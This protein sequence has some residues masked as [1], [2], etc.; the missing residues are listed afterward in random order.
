MR[1]RSVVVSLF[2]ILVS[3][4]C[5]AAITGTVITTDGLAVSGAKVAIFVP[6]SSDARRVRLLSKTPTR[7]PL[8]TAQSDSKGNF[9]IEAPKEP[10]LDVRIEANGYAP[11]ATRTIGDE[12]LGAI[13]LIAAPMLKGTIT[14][15]GKAVSGAVIVA[16]GGAEYTTTT[17]ADG[18]YTL[19]DPTK[20]ANRLVILHPDHAV[21]EE[22]FGPFGNAKKGLDRSLEAGVS[23]AGKVVSQ[24]GTTGVAN[25]PIFVDGWPV[26][27]TGE[28][29]TFKVAHAAKDWALV[30][31]RVDNR[32]G[33]RAHAAGN[34]AIKLAKAAAIAGLVLDSKTQT[35]LAGVEVRLMPAGMG[36]GGGGNA[37]MGRSSF[38]NAKGG[39][40][41]SSVLPGAYQLNPTR[42]GF[43]IP[44]VSVSVIAGQSAQKS[45]YANARAR[46]LGSVT[47]EDKRPV[48]GARVASRAAARDQMTMMMGGRNFG[49]DAGTYSAPDGRFVLRSVATDSDIQIDAQKKGYPS[50]RSATLKLAPAERKSGVNITVPRG[51]A[52]TGKVMDRDGRG[53]SGVGV[54]AVEST[55]DGGFG[56]GARRMILA[57][58]NARA[59][60]LVRTTSDG[61]FTIRV[62]EGT[63]DVVFKREGFA[64]KTVRGQAVSATT[65]PLEVT[66]DPGVEITGRVTRNG[67]GVEGV[68]VAAMSQDG[69]ASAISGPDG[70]FRLEDL[71]PGQMMLT[72]GKREEFIQQ[73]RPI[74]APARDVVIEVPAGGRISGRVVDKNT[75]APVTAFQAGISTSRGGGGMM[76]MTPPMLKAFTTDDGT[77]TLENVP[78]GPTQ[79]VVSA[80]GYTTTRLPSITV[81]EGKPV[82]DL[83]VALDTG[84]KLTGRVTGPD[85]GPLGGVTVRQD[86]MQSSGRMIARFD[87]MESSTV[88]DPSGEYTIEAIE[89]GEKSFSFTRQGYLAETKTAT[90]SGSSGRLDAQL[91]TGVRL[92]GSVVSEGGGPV[93]E[94]LV[95]ASSASNSG[96]GGGNQARTDAS[97]NFQIEGLAPGHY[98]LSATKT[99]YTNGV[100]RDF[101][102]AAGAPARIIMK[103]GGTIMG[104]VT[105]LT[106]QELRSATVSANSANGNASAPVDAS[107]NFK[108][109][110]APVGTVRVSARTG[111]MFAASGKSS[112]MKS[113]QVEPGA[114]VQVDLEFKSGTVVRG[115]VTRDNRVLANAGVVFMP[116]G[117][118]SQ[119]VASATTDANG[120][121]EISGLDDATY[122]V[123][124]MDFA[125]TM[126]FTTTYEVK[127]S[128]TF[129]IDIKASS[130]RGRVTDATTGA[131]LADAR[132]EIHA[133]GSD[134]MMSSRVVTTDSNGA[135]VFDSVARGNY[136]ARADKEGYGHDLRTVVVGDSPEDLEFKLSPSG[137]V[138]LTVVDARDNRQISA[139]VGRIVDAQG[140]DVDSIPNFRFGGA[141]EPMKLTLSSGTYRITL[142]AMGYA[143]QTVTV[144]S[145]SN[146]TV[147][148]TPGGSV[149][150]RSKSTTTTRARLVDSNGLAYM[151]SAFGGTG[152]V[153]TVDANPGVTT[154]QNIAPGT[155]RLEVLG[156]GD[157][158]IKTVP[159][160]VVDGQPTQVE[161]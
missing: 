40:T 86:Q 69:N 38:T 137:G 139:N 67:T 24:D 128:G 133:P 19:P 114:S 35:P 148:M 59:E 1:M 89:P 47:D 135:F 6:E 160:T 134:T 64:A 80:A 34:L 108:L 73:F 33:S 51:I 28:D 127:G 117:A 78:P 84:V 72:A 30:E 37:G 4:P 16:G 159:L 118:Q 112:P 154:L 104:H 56:G 55:S 98:M 110:G 149:V 113:V 85:G 65:K 41:L 141:L 79:I 22:N 101:D 153:F 96:F 126:P 119:T 122:N 143:T 125:R 93:G 2:G 11:D 92:T 71:T 31:A 124:V 157:Q 131:P 25:A 144:V 107:G 14:A 116:K 83:E 13:A 18:R 68:N 91:T 106:D 90:L 76:I 42:P 44:N 74:T 17:D 39:Y 102:V 61:T 155:F 20:W 60:N 111:G 62:K 43:V 66:L 52:L 54:E 49:Q 152:G 12:D 9:S 140:R 26:A 36:M 5:F 123:Q 115:R 29:G 7:T 142:S 75:H 120:H 97:G 50:G 138:T 57:M 109:E 146:P 156:P 32:I 15:G 46:V 88:T 147:R 70:S 136:E 105:G 99:G 82:V 94:A 81:E 63:Y 158:V 27:T 150:I 77:F 130:L 3:L 95:T 23:I 103:S 53:V 151:R 145:P 100:L 129:D 45:L 161:I 87:T 121:Y 48:A 132:I 58:Q 8:A 21:V 10:L